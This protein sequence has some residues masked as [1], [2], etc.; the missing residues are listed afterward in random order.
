MFGDKNLK[1]IER[2][3]RNGWESYV[4]NNYPGSCCSEGF[5]RRHRDLFEE[6]YSEN[7]G[8]IEQFI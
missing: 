7:I 6:W 3:K 2:A 4:I 5:Y 1:R 8:P